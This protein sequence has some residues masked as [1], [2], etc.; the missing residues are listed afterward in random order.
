MCPEGEDTMRALPLLLLLASCA[1]CPEPAPP[2][3]VQPEPAE[4]AAVP[5]LD[6]E[7]WCYTLRVQAPDGGEAIIAALWRDGVPVEVVVDEFAP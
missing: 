5:C 7:A 6:G 4:A 2:C 1:P 3:P